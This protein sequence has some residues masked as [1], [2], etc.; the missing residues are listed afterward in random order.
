MLLVR[1]HIDPVWNCILI[2][3]RSVVTILHIVS[4]IF[5]VVSA[6]SPCLSE[7]VL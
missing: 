1:N 3:P 7:V 6:I 4:L 2:F 5:A